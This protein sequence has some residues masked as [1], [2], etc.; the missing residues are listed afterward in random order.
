MDRPRTGA[1]AAAVLPSAVVA[2]KDVGQILRRDAGAMVLDLNA[3][4][5]RLRACAR[6]TT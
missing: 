2:V 5:L 6:S 1:G 3:A 4:A